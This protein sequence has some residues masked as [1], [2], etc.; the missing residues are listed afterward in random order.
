MRL[1]TF[2]ALSSLAILGCRSDS[3]NNSD[4]NNNGDGNGSNGGTVT[5]QM[6]QNDAMAPG[7]P[8]SL[9]GVVVTAIDAFGGKTGDIWVEEPEGGTYSG[10]HVFGAP[11]TA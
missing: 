6:V 4:G 7:T 8:V 10:I 9:K 3:N 2:L 11:A 5:I 1:T